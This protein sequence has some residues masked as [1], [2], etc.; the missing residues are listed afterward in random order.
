MVNATEGIILTDHVIEYHMFGTI[1]YYF[2]IACCTPRPLRLRTFH[3]IGIVNTY[4]CTSVPNVTFKIM[5]RTFFQY[6]LSEAAAIN[7]PAHGG[8]GSRSGQGGLPYFYINA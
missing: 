3:K 5:W 6:K 4:S 8:L 7:W 1:L 2:S